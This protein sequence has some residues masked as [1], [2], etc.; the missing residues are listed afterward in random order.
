MKAK[1]IDL[2]DLK[3]I[4]GRLLSKGY[5]INDLGKKFKVTKQFAH[6]VL[7]G[8]HNSPIAQGIRFF[9]ADIIGDVV[10]NIWR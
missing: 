9:V 2:K 7:L 4:R 6:Q 5:T 8:H 3:I 10:E 1:K